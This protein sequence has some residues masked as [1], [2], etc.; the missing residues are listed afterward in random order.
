MDTLKEGLLCC[1]FSSDGVAVYS[2]QIKNSTSLRKKKIGNYK[3][4]L[5]VNVNR[6]R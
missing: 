6:I 3:N 5:M 1:D 4:I 2:S